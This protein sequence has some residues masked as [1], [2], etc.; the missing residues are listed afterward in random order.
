[1]DNK[2]EI[3]SVVEKLNNL[4]EQEISN[5]QSKIEQFRKVTSLVGNLEFSVKDMEEKIEAVIQ[6]LEKCLKDKNEK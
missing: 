3:M 5:I 2:K 1:M 6:D 4:K